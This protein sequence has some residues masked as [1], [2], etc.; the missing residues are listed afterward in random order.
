MASS[1]HC[2][3]AQQGGSKRAI[4]LQKWAKALINDR[5]VLPLSL[6]GTP[7]N[8]RIDD[9]DVAAE[10]TTHLQSLGP[11][12]QALDIVHYTAIPKVQAQLHLK[13]AIHLA[14]VQRWMKKMGYRWTKKPLGQYVDGHERADVVFYHQTVFLPAWAELDKWTRLWT[15]DNQEIINEALT[16]GWTVVVWFHD[17]STFYAN[18]W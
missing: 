10:I 17:E 13:K 2:A 14:T 7:H 8:C 11:Y 9:Q 12:I 1:L 18:D 6:T 5:D 16:N 4:N 3:H 15:S